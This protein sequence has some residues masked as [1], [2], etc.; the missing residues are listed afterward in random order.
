MSDYPLWKDFRHGARVL[1][2]NRGFASMALA[3]LALGIGAATAIFSFVDAV[4]LRPVPY[5]TADRIVRV[6]ETRPSGETA[7]VSTPDFLDWQSESTAFEQL[8]AQQLGL[9]TLAGPE[10]VAVR[11]AR[12]SANFFDVF[13]VQAALGR[14]FVA[15]EDRSGGERVAVLSYSLWQSRFGGDPS[16]VSRSIVLDG[17]PF[18]VV[19]VLG[20][21][22]GFDRGATQIW[23]PLVLQPATQTRG[24]R[25]LSATFGLLAPGVSLEQARSQLT[26]IAA[27]LAAAYPDTNA[28]SSVAVDSYADAM[29]GADLATALWALLAA[30]G[31][32]LLICCAN[33]A[34]LVLA[35]AMARDSEIAIRASLGAT[36]GRIVQQLVCENLA[37]ATGGSILGL[38][39]AWAAVVAFGRLLPAGTLPSESVVSVDWRVIAFAAATTVITAVLF[40]LAPVVRAGSR[41]LRTGGRGATRSRNARRWLDGVV[42]AE[43]MLAVVLLS[44]A[45]LLMRSFLDLTGVDKGFDARNVLTMRLPVPGFP[46]GSRY[47]TPAEFTEYVRRIQAAVEALPGVRAAALSNALP[48]VDCCMNG[49]S[50]EVEGRATGDRASRG[51]GYYKVVTASYLRTLGLTIARGR[52]LEDGDN[53]AGRR[54]AVINER[55]AAR[56]FPNEDP[57]GKRLLNPEI[58]PGRTDRGA[59]VA[60]EIVGVVHDEKITS[61]ADDTSAVLYVSY[62]Q[63]PVY[64]MNLAVSGVADAASLEP[65]VRRALLAVSAEQAVLDV[66]TMERIESA[67]VG[68]HR[69]RTALLAVFSLVAL[70]LASVGIFGVLAYSVAQR[71]QELGIRAA[72]GASRAKLVRGVLRQGLALTAVGLALGLGAAYGVAPL[73][74]PL[75]Y[76]TSPHD[77]ALLAAVA[78][79][80]LA[81]G[82]GASAAPA[83]R[84]ARFDP[85]R[86]LRGE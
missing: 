53:A 1:A 79:I 63:G 41:A 86:V 11:A 80:F 49:L 25:W 10:P 77:G 21:K 74:Q 56:Y 39:L 14:T 67:S 69:L 30:V 6:L 31:G 18:V 57:L 44:S 28:D 55:L 5:S 54:V 7:W 24:Y 2:R 16:I 59:D 29:V 20:P 37:L 72:L 35:R 51:G 22:S 8:A 71:S 65:A 82:I 84:A 73:L 27:R 38:A 83:Y 33:V 75:L 60:W 46:P 15:G 9:V 12:V 36:R 17:T 26:A 45:A 68:S 23:Q 85:N 81:V 78:G 34:S 76:R 58:L 47:S 64:F 40:G 4:L 42:V 19:G 61:L 50:L 3:T 62:E 43:V 66:R 52:F 13:G 48:L 70:V 32:L